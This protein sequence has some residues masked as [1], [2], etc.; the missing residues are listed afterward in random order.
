GY[1]P[2]VQVSRATWSTVANL[3]DHGLIAAFFVAE[4]LWRQVRF[5]DRRQGPVAYAKAMAR[6][7]PAVR[8]G[9]FRQARQPGWLILAGASGA[10]RARHLHLHHRR[11]PPLPARALPGPPR[12]ARRGAAG[13]GAGPDRRR[14]WPAAAA[15][16][17][18]RPSPAAGRA[19]AHRAGRRGSALALPRAA[20]RRA[21]GQR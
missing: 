14:T 6:L 4:F 16:G 12:R 1:A 19:G 7:G 3:L 21:A 15:Q 13:T 2:P 11:R 5:P 20:R 10:G 18:V 8:R 17:E 9:L